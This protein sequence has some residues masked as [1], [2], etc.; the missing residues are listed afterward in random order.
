MVA[1]R[2]EAELLDWFNGLVSVTVLL[3]PP[4]V[5]PVPLLDLK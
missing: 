2:R 4:N 1:L 5:P 3:Q